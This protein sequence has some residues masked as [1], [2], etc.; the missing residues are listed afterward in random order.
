MANS[1]I[2]A[3]IG[4]N[5]AGFKTGLAK[6]RA[7]ASNFK[8]SVGGMFR[9]VGG[10]ISARYDTGEKQLSEAKKHSDYLKTI[11]ENT[12]NQTTSSNILMQ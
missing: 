11:A 10:N 7:M 5:S 12:E 6:C 1:S 3:K 2:I 9:G 4:L 8:A